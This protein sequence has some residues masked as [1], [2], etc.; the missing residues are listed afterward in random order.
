M[1]WRAA[2]QDGDIVIRRQRR[3]GMVVYVLHI[4]PGPD[5]Y[6][7]RSRDEAVRQALKLARHAKVSAWLTQDGDACEL[8]E[9][10]RV[11]ESV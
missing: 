10:F 3:E 6:L 4:A 2:P 9:G 8:L 7:V 5:Q 11:Q 1:L